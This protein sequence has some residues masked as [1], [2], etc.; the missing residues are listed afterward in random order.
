MR[1]VHCPS[2]DA[3]YHVVKAEAGPE[4]VNQP[5]ACRVC[6]GPFPSREKNVILKYFLLREWSS[7]QQTITQNGRRDI[8]IASIAPEIGP[9]LAAA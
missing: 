4:T 2:C 1:I 9:G 7:H 6:D 3:L 5:I 8:K